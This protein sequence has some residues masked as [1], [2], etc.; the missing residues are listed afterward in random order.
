MHLQIAHNK[1]VCM[2][3]GVHPHACWLGICPQTLDHSGG[4][5]ACR[6]RAEGQAPWPWAWPHGHP[7]PARSILQRGSRSPADTR[8]TLVALWRQI[9][10]S[11]SVPLHP[12]GQVAPGLVPQVRSMKAY[13]GPN[14]SRVRLKQ[15]VSL[16]VGFR[17][18]SSSLY[19]SVSPQLQQ[20]K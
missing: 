2:Q 16:W 14:W 9:W 13:A 20:E 4:L 10:A 8:S 6:S 7:S 17:P 15:R 12:T 19:A 11:R 5:S 1:H 3:G 18:A